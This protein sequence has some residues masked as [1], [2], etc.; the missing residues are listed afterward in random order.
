MEP[1]GAEWFP[2]PQPPDQRLEPDEE[3]ERELRYQKLRALCLA[4]Y[5]RKF[6]E[7]FPPDKPWAREL[8]RVR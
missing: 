2:V 5:M 4:E 8:P 3:V 7:L 1:E 6:D